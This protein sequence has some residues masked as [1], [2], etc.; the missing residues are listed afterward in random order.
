MDR[1][2]SLKSK[3]HQLY[4]GI[5]DALQRS[6]PPSSCEL[7]SRLQSVL[8][9]EA[10]LSSI[11][12]DIEG[13]KYEDA[14][15]LPTIRISHASHVSSP[16]QQHDC[17][18]AGTKHGGHAESPKTAATQSTTCSLVTSALQQL[19]DEF[20]Q[21]MHHSTQ[22]Q[23]PIRKHKV[24]SMHRIGA[25]LGLHCGETQ[26]RLYCGVF[27]LIGCCTVALSNLHS[28]ST[29]CVVQSVNKRSTVLRQQH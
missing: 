7:L 16:Q 13:F 26:S 24:G 27:F 1:K 14:V 28:I 19:K 4:C 18:R 21:K 20:T 5:A 11:D 2:E 6:A 22:Q 9:A 23:Q 8:E 10:C 29:P 25:V 12:D 17:K 3:R 15:E